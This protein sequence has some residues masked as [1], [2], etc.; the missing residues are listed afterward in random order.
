MAGMGTTCTALAIVNNEAWA[1]HVGDSRL[2][3]IR[4]DGHLSDFGRPH[5]G[6]PIWVRQGLLTAERS[7]ET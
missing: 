1:A 6:S 4:G 5:R 7:R 2:Y 3:F